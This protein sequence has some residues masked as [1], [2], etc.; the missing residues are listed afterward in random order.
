MFSTIIQG[1]NKRENI[2]L[3]HIGITT[4]TYDTE[5]NI[6]PIRWS[7]ETCMALNYK[8]YGDFT[9]NANKR[10]SCEAHKITA[11]WS[12]ILLTQSAFK[13]LLNLAEYNTRDSIEKAIRY[14]RQ[15]NESR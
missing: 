12:A 15:Y 4:E 13:G 10:L 6:C 14:I 2:I 9:K 3:D 7:C 11:Y 5:C 8:L 1:K